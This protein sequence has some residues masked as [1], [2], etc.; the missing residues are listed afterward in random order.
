MEQDSYVRAAILDEKNMEYF[1]K[2]VVVKSPGGCSLPACDPTKEI[3][4][5]RI[6]GK[7]YA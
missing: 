5:P 6:L 2:K 1:I 7:M 4:E 3:C